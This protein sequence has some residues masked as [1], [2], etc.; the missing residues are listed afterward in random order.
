MD[1]GRTH[2]RARGEVGQAQWHVGIVRHQ[3]Q[4]P[5]VKT[6]QGQPHQ[7]AQVAGAPAVVAS[8]QRE[9]FVHRFSQSEE[10]FV[11][12]AHA[13]EPALPGHGRGPPLGE[14]AQ[15]RRGD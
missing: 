9:S 3:V 8:R 2:L 1:V 15:R 12:P 6:A 5:L 10:V 7:S 13:E 14:V 11:S 4:H